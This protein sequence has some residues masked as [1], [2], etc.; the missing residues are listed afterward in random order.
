MDGALNIIFEG[1]DKP[2]MRVTPGRCVCELAFK[3]AANEQAITVM[4]TT[5]SKVYSFSRK[6]LD[7]ILFD[8]RPQFDKVPILA[9]L[10]KSKRD[11]V[12][13]NSKIVKIKKGELIYQP[14]DSVQN[15]HVILK[16]E[17]GCHLA[18]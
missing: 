18:F 8:V 2:P 4:S 17:H 6:E 15:F 16:G 5:P 12:A 14:G 10:S 7:R 9:R 3:H 13:Q 11:F 1:T